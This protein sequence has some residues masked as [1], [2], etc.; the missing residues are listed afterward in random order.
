MRPLLAIAFAALALAGCTGSDEPGDDAPA[1][2]APTS[3]PPRLMPAVTHFEFPQSAGCSS[4]G[5][6]VDPSVPITCASFQGGPDAT[7]IDGH[8]LALDAT[9]T[10]LRLTTTMGAPA[11][12][13]GD[14][15]C[16]FFA[17]DAATQTGD[18]SNGTGPCTGVVPIGT[19]WLF[20]YPYAAPATAM[21]ADFTA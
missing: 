2:P 13:V 6:S 15:D 1:D 20:L 5:H 12:A 8:W 4:E 3:T 10:G 7:G 17:P 21:T 16:Y 19:G 9:Y 11:D 18:G 14:S